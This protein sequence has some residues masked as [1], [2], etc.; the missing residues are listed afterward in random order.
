M[1]TYKNQLEAAALQR[2][3]KVSHSNLQSPTDKHSI[4]EVIQKDGF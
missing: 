2:L 1:N 4:C 3:Q